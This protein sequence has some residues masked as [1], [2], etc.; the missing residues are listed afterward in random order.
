VTP[1][2][3]VRPYRPSDRPAVRDICFRTGYMGE[4]ADWF[5]RDAPSFADAFSGYYTDHEPESALVAARGHDGEGEVVGYLLGCVDSERAWNP[6]AVVGR[7]IVRRG[8]ALRPGT[9]G[10]IWRTMAEGAVDLA[11]GRTDRRMLEFADE[12]YPA[13]VHCDLLAEARG[14]GLGRTMV[15]TWLDRLRAAGVPGCHLQTF[16][17]NTGGIAFWEACGFRRH[18]DAQLAPG[19]RTRDGA[20]MHVQVMV[21]DL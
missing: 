6:A 21:H 12:R 18:G 16:A 11:R 15:H 8:L 19:Y 9:A 17:E 4:P 20:R 3:A 7:H 13:H 14:Q 1:S 5:W 10:L 2:V